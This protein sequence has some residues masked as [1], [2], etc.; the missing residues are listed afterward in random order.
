M[1]QVSD[2]SNEFIV[3]QSETSE[4][5]GVVV[6]AS[7]KLLKTQNLKRSYGRFKTNILQPSRSSAVQLHS[8]EI[9]LAPI[10]PLAKVNS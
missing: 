4:K 1:D 9:W 10:K 6:V 5:I 8:Y 3:H 7:V 2:L